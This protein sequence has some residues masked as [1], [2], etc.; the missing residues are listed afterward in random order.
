M[1]C[2]GFVSDICAEDSLGLW[3]VLS[4]ISSCIL[5]DYVSISSIR[6]FPITTESDSCGTERINDA[7]CLRSELLGLAYSSSPSCSFRVT[8]SRQGRHK[9]S[10]PEAAG[11]LGYGLGKLYPLWKVD[12]QVKVYIT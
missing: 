3:V 8:C 5:S 11:N 9:Y 6:K 12:L 7:I 4:A 2:D 1:D 10:S